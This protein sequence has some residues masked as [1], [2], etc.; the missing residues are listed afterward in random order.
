MDAQEKRWHLARDGQQYGPFCDADV[1]NF[2]RL[3]QLQAKGLI[4]RDGFAGWRPALTVFPEPDPS[5]A[6]ALPAEESM[7]V[8][9]D[10]ERR[11]QAPP[12]ARGLTWKKALIALACAAAIGAIATYACKYAFAR[13]AALPKS[14]AASALYKAAT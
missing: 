6:Q 4:W 8:R 7:P 12:R 14:D 3:G 9:A 1:A 10:K 2:S 5:V 13:L 11:L